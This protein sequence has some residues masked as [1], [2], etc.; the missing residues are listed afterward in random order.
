MSESRTP[1]GV[2]ELKRHNKRLGS[3]MDS[4]TLLRVRELKRG[5]QRSYPGTRQSHPS[6]GA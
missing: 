3:L 2:R 5:S 6:Q 1:P 4:R